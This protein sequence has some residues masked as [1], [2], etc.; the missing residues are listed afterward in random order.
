[1]LPDCSQ[2]PEWVCW[3][4]QDSDGSWWGYEHEPNM[5]DAGWYE[6]EVGRSVNLTKGQPTARWRRQIFKIKTNNQ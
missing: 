4:A 2:L 5:A 3:I 1:M 6:N